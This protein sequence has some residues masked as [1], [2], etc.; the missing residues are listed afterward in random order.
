MV[1]KL[2]SLGNTIPAHISSLFVL[3]P[4]II[5]GFALLAFLVAY[6]GSAVLSERFLFWGGFAVVIFA[7]SSGIAITVI[8]L[9]PIR[10]F[11]TTVHRSPTFAREMTHSQSDESRKRDF[12]RFNYVFEEMTSII[13]KVDARERFP[14]IVGQSRVMRNVL[15]QVIKVG[16]TDATV[17]ILG[18]SG[19]GKEL[20]ATA[21]H[22][23]SRRLDKPFIK[24]NCV[25]IPTGLLESELFGHEK[26]SFT[27]AA[28]RKIGKFEMAHEGT[29]FLD[30]IGDM[31]LETQAKLLRV[32]QER[33]FERVGG[34]ETIS[35]DVRFIAASN[36]NLKHMVKEG[37]FRDDLFYRLN[38]FT[39][40]MPPLRERLD[41]IPPLSRHILTMTPGEPDLSAEAMRELMN[42]DWPGNV[43]ELIN[44]LTRA[45]VMAEDGWITKIGLARDGRSSSSSIP[46]PGGHMNPQTQEPM[47]DEETLPAGQEPFLDDEFNLDERLAALEQEIIIQALKKTGG[48]QS[49][50]ADL[51]GIKQRSLWHRVKKYDIDVEDTKKHQKT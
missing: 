5:T 12:N 33:E 49:K 19:V 21:L 42:Y 20:I 35:V 18:E 40:Y 14:H 26:G 44:V 28:G 11:I 4:F 50:A 23:E 2:K 13:S 31:P 8:I 38:V 43:R 29:L 3:I 25:A 10:K 45:S 34:N 16:P 30:E 48:V 22:E 32:L 7:A 15:S 36:K 27:G 1:K 6:H 47:I 24:L 39:I 41:D 17:L 46:I 9:N 51:L 37:T